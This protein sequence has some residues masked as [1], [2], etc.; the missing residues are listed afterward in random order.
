M[1]TMSHYDLVDSTIQGFYSNI[2]SMMETRCLNDTGLTSTK[3]QERRC[4]HTNSAWTHISTSERL[5]KVCECYAQRDKIAAFSSSLNAWM[6]ACVCVCLVRVCLFICLHVC[7]FVFL[8]A[9][10][11]LSRYIY[12]A[13]LS[14]MIAV[15]SR[16][17]TLVSMQDNLNSS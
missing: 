8:S 14:N 16:L 4:Y 15:E 11:F 10:L 1:A 2:S 17:N 12:W 7:I 5:F 6:C 9:C 13:I 3:S